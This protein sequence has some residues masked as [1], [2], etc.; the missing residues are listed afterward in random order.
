M[1]NS[2]LNEYVNFENLTLLPVDKISVSAFI[3][4][5]K[6]YSHAKVEDFDLQRM[7]IR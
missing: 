5:E 2:H 7:E 3:A 6:Q 4:H 1:G